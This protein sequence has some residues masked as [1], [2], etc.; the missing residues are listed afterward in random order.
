M[1]IHIGEK[2]KA[3][4]KER[5]IGTTELAKSINTSKQNIYGLFKR[6]SI[7]TALLQ[8]FCG[9]LNYDFFAYYTNPKLPPHTEIAENI[10]KH[11]SYS[12]I[13]NEH[14]YN[15]L[16]NQLMDLKEKYELVKKV[17]TLLEGKK[18]KK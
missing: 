15:M 8:K 6:E 7:D 10:K 2:I 16:R 9:A 11:K 12:S 3:Q 18:K 14:E 5:R 4:A 1:K 17:N 13:E